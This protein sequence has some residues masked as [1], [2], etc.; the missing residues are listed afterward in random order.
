[1]AESCSTSTAGVDSDVSDDA[2]EDLCDAS[3]SNEVASSSSDSQQPK[4]VRSFLDTLKQ[5]RPSDS[6]V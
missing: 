1:M 2:S 5:A 3:V 4:A 6:T